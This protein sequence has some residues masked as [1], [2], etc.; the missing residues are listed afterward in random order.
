MPEKFSDHFFL[1]VALNLFKIGIEL[2]ALFRKKSSVVKSPILSI[3]LIEKSLES[4]ISEILNEY[5]MLLSKL[6]L[7]VNSF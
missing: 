3:S 5:S 1:S 2:A 6:D 7:F 4:M